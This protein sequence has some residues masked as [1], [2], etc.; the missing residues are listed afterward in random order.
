M[1]AIDLPVSE[2]DVAADGVVVG[3]GLAEVGDDEREADVVERR[4][5]DHLAADEVG[6]PRRGR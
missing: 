4:A 3:L 1:A 2:L 6:V 5:G